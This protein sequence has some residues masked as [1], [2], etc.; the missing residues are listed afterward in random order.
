MFEGK[1]PVPPLANGTHTGDSSGAEL[2][3]LTWSD[4][5]AR[6]AA[7]RDLRREMAANDESGAASFDAS[8]ALHIA[9]IGDRDT[10]TAGR[11]H[12]L[13]VN[14]D[15]LANGKTDGC[16]NGEHDVDRHDGRPRN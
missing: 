1:P 15:D 13:L 6:L 10:H 14:P 9:H 7:A 12:Q 11:G 2:C 5:V 3:A 8:S 4:L 16:N